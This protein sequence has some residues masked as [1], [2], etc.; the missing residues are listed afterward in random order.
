MHN[1][2]FSI[3]NAHRDSQNSFLELCLELVHE[4][5]EKICFVIVQKFLKFVPK[6]LNS[7][8]ATVLG[9][10]MGGIPFNFYHTI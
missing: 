10:F 3:A 2:H 6:L 5:H 4:L 8:I 7:T 1:A 9:A